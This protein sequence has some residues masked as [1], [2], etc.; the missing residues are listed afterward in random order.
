M[1]MFFFSA[2]AT[3]NNDFNRT[4][5]Q[6]CRKGAFFLADMLQNYHEAPDSTKLRVPAFWEAPLNPFG[7]FTHTAECIDHA[8]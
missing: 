1:F 2:N 4:H 5:G 3:I 7:D 6:R 8:A